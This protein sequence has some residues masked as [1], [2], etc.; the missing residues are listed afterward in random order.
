MTH[1]RAQPRGASF[2]AQASP[3]SGATDA[4]MSEGLNG[5]TDF[6][7]A[8]DPSQVCHSLPSCYSVRSTAFLSHLP[9]LQSPVAA[10]HSAVQVLSVQ[11]CQDPHNS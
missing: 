11:E 10:K 1:A 3:S 7:S 2:A 4:I 5:V 9:A 8:Y 6:G